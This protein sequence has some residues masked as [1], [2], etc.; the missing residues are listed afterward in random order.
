MDNLFK[1]LETIALGYSQGDCSVDTLIKASNNYKIKKN[2]VDDYYYELM[3]TKSCIDSINRVPQDS[4]IIKSIVPGQTKVID[5]VL[6]IYSATKKGSKTEYDWHVVRKGVK[7]NAEIGRGS[8]LTEKDIQGKQKY[9]NELFPNDLSSLKVVKQLN[10]STGAQLVE[11]SDGNQYVLKRGKNTN[12]D[13]VKSEYLSNQLY[14]IMGLRTP[15]Y[16][17]YDDNGEA[18]LLSRFIQGTHVPNSSDF[19]KMSKGFI[20]DALLAN[21]D[22]YQNDNCLIKNATGD[23]FRVDNGGCLKYR[24]QGKIKTFDGDVYDTWK[25]MSKYNPGIFN[26]LSEDDQLEQINDILKKKDD[27]VNFLKE[28]GEDELADIMSLRFD[29]LKRISDEL[30]FQKNNKAQIAAAKLGKITPRTLKSNDEMYAE[31]SEEDISQIL[32]DTAKQVGRKVDDKGI[33]TATDSRGWALLGNICKKRGFDARPEVLSEEDFWKRRSTTKWP[34]MFRGFSVGQKGVDDFKFNDWCHFGEYGI[35]GQGVYAHSDDNSHMGSKKDQKSSQ[36][37]DL[38]CTEKNW[39]SAKSYS[40]SG[41]SAIGYS[42]GSAAVKMYW[43]PD[44]NVIS[45]EDLLDEI[46]QIGKTANSSPKAKQLKKELDE[47]KSEWTKN[48]LALINIEDVVKKQV[49]STIGYDEDSVADLT[50]FLSNANWGSR[51][52]Q[53][54]RNYPMFDEVV[55]GKIKPCVEKCGGKTELLN[56]GRDD[57][58]LHIEIG[59]NDIYIS[60]YSW[61]N[62]AVKQKN[63]FTSPYH[64]QAERFMTF[65]DTNCVKVAH[66]AVQKELKE[67]KKSKELQEA[68][69]QNKKDYYDKQKEYDEETKVT[70]V[71]GTD[72][73][74][75]IYNSVKN[76]EYRTSGDDK[77]LLGIYAA[78]KGYDGIYQ[79]DGNGSGHGFVVILNRSKI[80]TS[81]E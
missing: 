7:T 37:V 66:D 18:V 5:G 70:S 20:A 32:D 80:I 74:S 39:K 56:S 77:S 51:N 24:A 73:Y 59:N 57:E 43:H 28:S 40:G 8:K 65:F 10:G 27:V 4:E 14:S 79:P 12:S 48:E 78:L 26:L 60:K 62:N 11:D 75:R 50:D 41:E 45:S 67:G 68:I 29:G 76:C 33:L 81:I 47:I 9:L 71:N 49:Y 55:L 31:L 21:W 34:M 63:Q 19:D 52:A 13:H 46:K 38:K 16:E 58:Q 22:V 35:W 6:Y 23:V 42:S 15:D 61:N 72:L 30:T 53:G 44:A 54:N 25:S 69:A 2:I 36:L 3:V 64:F 17:L 1:A